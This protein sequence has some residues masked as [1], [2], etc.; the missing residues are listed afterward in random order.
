MGELHRTYDSLC[1]H[2]ASHILAS[3]EDVEEVVNDTM[4]AVWDSIPPQ[5]PASL[6]AYISKLTRNIAIT[7]LRSNTAT[8]RDQRMTA[9]LEELELVLPDPRSLE[10]QLESK[11]ITQTIN[12]YL[13]TL[14]KTNRIIFLRRYY[15]GDTT[16]EVAKLTGLTD[17][18]VRSRLLRMRAELRQQLEKEDIFV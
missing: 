15:C 6:P 3:P 8:L 1:R 16:K 7:R 17:Q 10:S 18:A 9:S 14:S 11:M 5:S 4:L 2:I 13:S 12:G